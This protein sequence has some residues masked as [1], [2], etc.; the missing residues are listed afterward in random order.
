MFSQ[1]SDSSGIMESVRF[2]DYLR[3]VLALP[4]AVFE[5]P[6][7]GFSDNSHKQCFETV[8]SI[9]TS[10]SLLSPLSPPQGSRVTVNMF[11][12]TLMAD[13]CPPCLMWLP[14]LHRMASV[15]HV[16]H[17][18]CCDGCGRDAFTGFRYRCQRCHN[19]QLCQVPTPISKGVTR[20][21]FRGAP[22][23]GGPTPYFSSQTPKSQGS[24]LC[25]FGY[26]RIS[27]GGG[28]PPA[29]PGYAL[30]YLPYIS[31]QDE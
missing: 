31:H 3:E 23:S 4:T 18:V 26:L 9:T 27:G 11:L 7:F 15:E 20:I 16:F 5:G 8:H 13:P 14:L 24:P 2:N 10:Q 17:P 12:D 19:Y 29:H 25:T 30:A 21:W 28:R 22:I 1:L 6:T